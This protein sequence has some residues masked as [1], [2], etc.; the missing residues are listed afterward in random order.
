MRTVVSTAEHYRD[1]PLALAK[2]LAKKTR[3]QGTKKIQQD[4]DHDSDPQTV[5]LT[6]DKTG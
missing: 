3:V 4:E 1:E 2:N 6:I 5:Y